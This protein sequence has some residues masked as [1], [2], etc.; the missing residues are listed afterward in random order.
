MPPKPTAF[1]AAIVLRLLSGSVLAMIVVGGAHGQP[2]LP[3]E[4]LR[5]NPV[6][7]ERLSDGWRWRSRF[8]DSTTRIARAVATT[9]GGE[10][11]ALDGNGL[12]RFDGVRWERLADTSAVPRSDT[13]LA[14][15]DAGALLIGRDLRL[16]T[17]AGT[18]PLVSGDGAR[19]TEPFETPDGRVLIGHGE[20][21]LIVQP[22]ASIK[23]LAP[24]GLEGNLVGVG[25][26]E[27]GHVWAVSASKVVEGH[28]GLWTPYLLPP[29]VGKLGKR[30]T[31]VS[32]N[33]RVFFANL[34]SSLQS[35]VLVV[36]DRHL[37]LFDV[38]FRS[39]LI[40]SLVALPGPRHKVLVAATVGGSLWVLAGGS[41]FSVQRLRLQ[42][43][44]IKRMT[45]DT[46]GRLNLV[47]A[48]GRLFTCIVGSHRW[49]AISIARGTRE[50]DWDRVND[51]APARQG[52]WWLATAA[53]IARYHEGEVIQ[54][55]V[56]QGNHV[57]QHLTTVY[58]DVQGRL[59]AGSGGAMRGI[60]YR[61]GEGSWTTPDVPEVLR[62]L[63]LHRVRPG[64]DG[65]IW[66]LMIGD[67]IDANG[68]AV[69]R[70]AADGAWTIW[71]PE[72]M[73]CAH[74][75]D[76]AF[77]SGNRPWIGTRAGLKRLDGTTWTSVTDGLAFSVA[78][79]KDDTVWFGQGLDRTGVSRYR[80]GVVESVTNAAGG[81]LRAGAIAIDDEDT[82]WCASAHG[83][84]MVRDGVAYPV[85]REAGLRGGRFWPVVPA[86]GGAWVGSSFRGLVRFRSDDA[87][88]PEI[89]HLRVTPAIDGES[90]AVSWST[91]DPWNLTRPAR[92]LHRVRIDGGS[93][94]RWGRRTRHE[95]VLGSGDHRVE[96]QAV[97]LFANRSLVR[98]HGFTVT[99]PASPGGGWTVVAFVLA[100]ILIFGL[101]AVLARRRSE[102]A[103]IQRHDQALLQDSERHYRELV[104]GTDIVVSHCG[105]SGCLLYVSPQIEDVTGE[106]PERFVD[107][108]ALMQ[109]LIHAEDLDEWARLARSR[110]KQTHAMTD[111]DF[112]VKHRDGSY[113]W[114]H[115]R[116]TARRASDGSLEGWD[117]IA[118]DVTRRKELEAA[119]L[120]AQKMEGLGLLAGG[121]AH[122]FNNLLMGVLGNVDLVRATVPKMH[123]SQGTLADIEGAARR[124]SQL[125]QQ[126]L[127]YAGKALFRARPLDLVSEIRDLGRLLH[128]SVPKTVTLRVDEGDAI[129]AVM[130]D[131][132]QL[133]QVLMNLV[134]NAAE[135]YGGCAGEVFVKT[136]V[137]DYDRGRLDRMHMGGEIAAGRYVSVEVRDE[138]SGIEPDHLA[139]IFDPFFTTRFDGRGLGLAAVLGIVG[140]HGGAIEVVST[141]EVGTTFR[142]VLPVDEDAVVP[143][144]PR[145]M[146]PASH[147]GGGI[148]LVIDDEPLVRTVAQSMLRHVGYVSLAAPSGADGIATFR[149][150][151]REIRA[152]ILDM[153]M[154]DM[155]GVQA[156]AGLRAI[157]ADIPVILVS[158][159]SESEV[160]ARFSDQRPTAFLSKPF[161]ASDLG[162]ILEIALGEVPTGDAAS[163]AGA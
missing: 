14:V 37:C 16:W 128:S 57:V 11:I 117:T 141:P 114:L 77:D 133:G 151:Q 157:R 17:P 4:K 90:T 27:G 110:E 85:G 40:S 97:D 3:V 73:G 52:G 59:W 146:D 67:P 135:S 89:T 131:P 83:L 127:A 78:I 15:I 25:E 147:T 125:C 10:W 116:Q 23:R 64:P 13:S 74:A 122:D 154:P 31:V 28:E 144:A 44:S 24:E 121:I 51:I 20:T 132:V 134:T 88:P 36:R 99:A 95:V 47:T 137:A 106:P 55:V 86:E 94:T 84:I 82:V 56:R 108:P 101:F 1:T 45:V 71:G 129:P 140:T 32:L 92:L 152:V 102:L 26:D 115:V 143:A 118:F 38:P 160:V 49:N 104:E 48:A 6:I 60:L 79:G 75:Y 41:W 163:A 68:G 46:F 130:G 5:S 19:F 120:H 21:I 162:Q 58:E 112:R 69:A 105:P 93:W 43:Q 65:S 76:V 159:Y 142:V 109:S 33:G 80:N 155:D 50:P 54:I 7:V 113:R 42:R 87:A 148:V 123:P 12:S 35:E 22:D 66:F 81:P 126:M 9:K 18:R 138:G 161:T 91:T 8:M 111:A 107:D 119:L 96:V 103:E 153:T 139:R 30:V 62:S 34:E 98:K 63:Y 100:G 124:A 145:Q 158:G 53:G 150:R 61:N 2:N 136:T 156:L 70:L 149:V 39:D 72:K 29:S